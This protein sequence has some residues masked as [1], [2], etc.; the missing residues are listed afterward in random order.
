MGDDVL[1]PSD[2]ASSVVDLSQEFVLYEEYF[3]SLYVSM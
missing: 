3:S 2:S 1:D